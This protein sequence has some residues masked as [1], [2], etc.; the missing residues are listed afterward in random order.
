MVSVHALEVDSVCHV[1][2]LNN[3]H[4]YNLCI[5]DMLTYRLHVYNIASILSSYFNFI[6]EFVM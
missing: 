3:V 6:F 4:Q 2:I 5:L 1:Y